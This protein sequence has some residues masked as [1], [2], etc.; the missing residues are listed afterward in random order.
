MSLADVNYAWFVQ[1]SYQVRRLQ[2]VV[3][4]LQGKEAFGEFTELS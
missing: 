3:D 4:T 2:A 1:S